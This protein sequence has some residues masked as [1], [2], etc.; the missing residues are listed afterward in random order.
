MLFQPVAMEAK[1][2][3]YNAI[4]EMYTDGVH[5]QVCNAWTSGFGL[6]IQDFYQETKILQS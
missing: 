1:C 6:T 3:Q 2:I 4:Y 5:G